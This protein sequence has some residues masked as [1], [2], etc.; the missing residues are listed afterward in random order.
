[1]HDAIL[2]PR[3]DVRRRQHLHQEDHRLLEDIL[4]LPDGREQECLRS[5]HG[6]HQVLVNIWEVEITLRV[7]SFILNVTYS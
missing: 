5:R 4:P 7:A 1:M 6:R 2:V 3:I